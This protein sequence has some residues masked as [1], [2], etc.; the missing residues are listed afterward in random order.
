MV[1]ALVPLRQ[2]E[3]R[4]IEGIGVHGRAVLHRTVPAGHY[5]RRASFA[6][7]FD[8]RRPAG[9]APGGQAVR[10]GPRIQ[11]HRS[12]LQTAPQ[13]PHPH[14]AALR[15]HRPHRRVRRLPVRQ[16]RL[17]RGAGEAG[18]V[19][20]PPRDRLLPVQADRPVHGGGPRLRLRE[21]L[22][23]PQQGRSVHPRAEAGH[24]R[25]GRRALDRR[26][27]PQR[28]PR[29]QDRHRGALRRHGHRRPQHVRAGHRQDAGFERAVGYA[30]AEHG[31]CPQGQ[32]QGEGPKSKGSSR[33]RINGCYVYL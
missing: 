25:A 13:G 4:R 12:G 3:Y 26:P 32:P 33:G 6:P 7:I 28:Q 1:D 17:R 18:R 16:V 8:R 24:G 27:H 2:V 14:H 23:H 19:P 22:P 20:P 15:L 31:K 9:E 10:L 5:H 21:L 29:R 11:Q 30:R